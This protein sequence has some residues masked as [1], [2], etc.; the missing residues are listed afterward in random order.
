[1]RHFAGASNYLLV[2]L[3]DVCLC[4]CVCVF[5]VHWQHDEGATVG[6]EVMR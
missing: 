3:A 2:G 6:G 1:M 5:R 4:V